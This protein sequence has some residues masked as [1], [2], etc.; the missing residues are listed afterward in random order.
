MRLSS[1]PVKANH[2]RLVPATLNV[3]GELSDGRNSDDAK[4]DQYAELT[5][6]VARD[7]GTTRADLRKACVA[8]LQNNN[9]QLRV[10]GTLYFKPSGV[11]TYDGVHP[12]AKGN[13]LLANLI[14]DGIIRGLAAD[15][16]AN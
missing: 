6:K 9:A 4:I 7:T 12:T 10:D 15:R 14:G 16:P 2:T 13:E 11:L 1:I 5:L 8:F 3:R